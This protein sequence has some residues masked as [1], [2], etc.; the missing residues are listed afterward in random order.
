VLSSCVIWRFR[1][2]TTFV[3]KDPAGGTRERQSL[4]CG[5]TTHD[6]IA[7]ASRSLG[8]D[9]GRHTRRGNSARSESVSIARIGTRPWFGPQGTSRVGEE[10]DEADDPATGGF[11][12]R[13]AR[14]RH[15]HSHGWLAQ[16]CGRIPGAVAR[17]HAL[18]AASAGVAR[19]SPQAQRVIWAA[20][21]RRGSLHA[22]RGVVY[23]SRR[24]ME[25]PQH[26]LVAP[27]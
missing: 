26:T 24:E 14:R 18:C 22:K 27:R 2:G 15:I 11:S 10:R 7:L 3:S 1:D 13:A 16:D 8:D 17:A 25:A 21:A 6:A 12:K 4:V 23:R 9:V 5:K 20:H 19:S